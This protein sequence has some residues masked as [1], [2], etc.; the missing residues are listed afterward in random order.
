MS[1]VQLSV[2]RLLFSKNLHASSNSKQHFNA[3]RYSEWLEKSFKTNSSSPASKRNS[4]LWFAPEPYKGLHKPCV[5]A[6][7]SSYSVK[8]QSA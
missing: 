2:L 6:I 7:F 3:G 8:S 1:V 5:R 4:N